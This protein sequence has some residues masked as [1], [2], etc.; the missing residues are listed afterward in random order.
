MGPAV[1]HPD[2]CSRRTTDMTGLLEYPHPNTRTPQLQWFVSSSQGYRENRKSYCT[3][4]C[5]ASPVVASFLSSSY[6]RKPVQRQF[7][8]FPCFLCFALFLVEMRTDAFSPNVG[9]RIALTPKVRRKETLCARTTQQSGVFTTRCTGA[10]GP[11]AAQF[12]ALALLPL[13]A[14]LIQACPVPTSCQHHLAGAS[15]S[16]P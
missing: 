11:T 5:V 12:S 14:V 15:I 1:S 9:M 6:T 3:S 7:H 8:Y 16:Q 4:T 10:E 2:S 13:R